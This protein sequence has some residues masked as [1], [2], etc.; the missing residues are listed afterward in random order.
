MK[1]TNWDIEKV[2]KLGRVTFSAIDGKGVKHEIDWSTP[3][4]EG[5]S[6][7]VEVAK[8]KELVFDKFKVDRVNNKIIKIKPTPNNPNKPNNPNTETTAAVDPSKISCCDI[9][10][11]KII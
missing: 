10:D 2:D 11:V 3:K 6:L 7:Y 1:S 9:N 4:E 5:G 8:E